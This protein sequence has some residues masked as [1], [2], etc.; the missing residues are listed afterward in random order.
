V[1]FNVY[2]INVTVQG[3]AGT[4]GHTINHLPQS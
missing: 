3:G 2:Q 1:L 4:N